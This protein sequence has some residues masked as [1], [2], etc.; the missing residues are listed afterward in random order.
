M[1]LPSITAGRAAA[2][3]DLARVQRELQAQVR[4]QAALKQQADAARAQRANEQQAAAARRRVQ[5]ETD[6]YRTVTADRRLRNAQ[7]LAKDTIARDADTVQLRRE[8]LEEIR[9]SRARRAILAEPN[10]TPR[11]NVN[12]GPIDPSLAFQGPLTPSRPTFDLADLNTQ[13]AP[14]EA[15]QP[16]EPVEGPGDGAAIAFEANEQARVQRISER[17]SDDQAF[18]AQQVIDQNLANRRIA[19]TP[20]DAE[21][22]R[23]SIVDVSG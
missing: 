3:A 9:D 14:L 5:D 6:D 17:R 4:Q 21:L 2:Q 7:L 8:I 15:L 22:P 18:N 11:Q 12:E 1:E 10:L 23:G 19:V 16:F 20:F 13:A